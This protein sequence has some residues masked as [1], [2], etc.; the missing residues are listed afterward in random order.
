MHGLPY[1]VCEVSRGQH[2]GT[3]N[4]TTCDSK[5]KQLPKPPPLEQQLA[6]FATAWQNE[7]WTEAALPS[8]A[9]G[10]PVALAKKMLAK[11]RK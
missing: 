5:C 1:A 11:Y 8:K 6:A 10:D 3:Y 4:G 2:T 7:T 9:V